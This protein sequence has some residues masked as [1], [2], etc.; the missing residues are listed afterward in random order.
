MKMSVYGDILDLALASFHQLLTWSAQHKLP[1]ARVK[2]QSPT[3]TTPVGLIMEDASNVSEDEFAM[4][5]QVIADTREGC[6][7]AL[8]V[9]TAVWVWEFVDGRL[10]TS[11]RNS[12]GT[13][14]PE[15]YWTKMAA[16]LELAGIHSLPLRQRS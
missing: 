2:K 9:D 4:V 7:D 5:R 14:S 8:G 11:S 16:L 10:T 6:I 3:T 13:L 12:G 1:L 15:S